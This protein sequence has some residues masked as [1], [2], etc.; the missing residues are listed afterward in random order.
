MPPPLVCHAYQ[1]HVQLQGVTP[2]VWRRLLVAPTIHLAQ[3]HRLVQAALD[4][5]QAQPFCFEIA[6]QCYGQPDPDHPEDPTMD[7]RRYTL[8]QLLQQELVP[9]RLVS[10]GQTLRLRVEAVLDT[11]V[12]TPDCIDGRQRSDGQPFHLANA[13][14]RVQAL[15]VALQVK[16]A[17]PA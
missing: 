8:G 2:V 4:W 1:L 11:P 16:S 14:L 17:E 13:R 12:V 5:H 3:L 15:Q 6:G 7:A 9:L 10:G